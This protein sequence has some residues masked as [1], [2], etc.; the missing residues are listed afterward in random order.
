[1]RLRAMIALRTRRISSSLL[2]LNMTPATTSIH[3]P[4]WWKGPL[5]PLTTGRDL[6]A[7]RPHATVGLMVRHDA[8]GE[9]DRRENRDRG[10]SRAQIVG[11]GPIAVR[12]PAGHVHSPP[13]RAPR[14]P[15]RR[16]RRPDDP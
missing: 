6:Y 14:G 1:M 16:A 12:G 13:S 10:V 9:D 5:G 7:V 8:V 15:A 11:P 3:P 4:V 2:P